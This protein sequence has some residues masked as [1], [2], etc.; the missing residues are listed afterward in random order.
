MSKS[1]FYM[2]F[3]A[4]IFLSCSKEDV[5]Q[6]ATLPAETALKD[7][8]RY[9]LVIEPYITFRDTPYEDGVTSSHAREGEVFA[10]ES[11]KVQMKNGKQLIW[12]ELQGA[13]WVQSSSLQLYTSKEKAITA[14]KKLK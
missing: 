2:F 11:I 3:L 8:S 13:G 14:S 12:V 1:I 6:E 5:V 4:L 9:A 7:F 10:V